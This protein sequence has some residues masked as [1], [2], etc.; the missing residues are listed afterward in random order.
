MTSELGLQSKEDLTQIARGRA[1]ALPKLHVPT[2]LWKSKDSH[3]RTPERKGEEMIVDSFVAAYVAR[4]PRVSFIKAAWETVLQTEVLDRLLVSPP[5]REVNSRIALLR[6]IGSL[7]SSDA[8]DLL[9]RTLFNIA[10]GF[11]PVYIDWAKYANVSEE[12]LNGSI[13]TTTILQSSTLGVKRPASSTSVGT[14]SATD[15]S[16]LPSIPKRVKFDHDDEAQD[17]NLNVSWDDSWLK[18]SLQQAGTDSADGDIEKEDESFTCRGLPDY[19]DDSDAEDS[20][21]V[22]AMLSGVFDDDDEEPTGAQGSGLSVSDTQFFIVPPANP[23]GNHLFSKSSSTLALYPSSPAGHSEEDST[24]GSSSKP[25]SLKDPVTLPAK[26]T[27]EVVS[28]VT[29]ASVDDILNLGAILRSKGYRSKVKEALSTLRTFCVLVDEHLDGL[30]RG[31]DEDSDVPAKR[32][33][34]VPNLLPSASSSSSE[35][36][37]VAPEIDPSYIFCF[38]KPLQT[39]WTREDVFGKFEEECCEMRYLSE[40]YTGI[41]AT[42]CP[43]PYL[44]SRRDISRPTHDSASEKATCYKHVLECRLVLTAVLHRLDA[45]LYGPHRGP[46]TSDGDVTQ[47]LWG[48]AKELL[49]R[50]QHGQELGDSWGTIPCESSAAFEKAFTLS[51]LLIKRETPG[52]RQTWQT[53]YRADHPKRLQVCCPLRLLR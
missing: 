3:T 13:D 18:A 6:H 27:D 43:W 26:P 37:S 46:R 9:S 4:W 2:E 28:P 17:N 1:A 8:Q 41:L 31:K 33:Q 39:S 10:D 45:P 15:T 12:Q 38:S 40:Y 23:G 51:L 49:Y 7:P 21:M 30:E 22:C 48:N 52:S 16:T 53:R 29:Q 50:G 47:T 24:L 25:T 5:E 36:A 20:A 35:S 19:E 44:A 32:P 42:A 14:S 11:H 34:S